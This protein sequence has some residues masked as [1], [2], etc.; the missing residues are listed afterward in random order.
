[1]TVRA[2]TDASMYAFLPFGE[3]VMV[4]SLPYPIPPLRTTTLV[5]LPAPFT[6]ALNLAPTPVLLFK[7]RRGAEVYSSPE[8]ETMTLVILPEDMTGVNSAFL[9]ML[10]DTCGFLW[11]FRISVP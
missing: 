2:L 10:R 1:M 5:I 3:T 11:K 6:T 7:V 8:A 4:V 9:P